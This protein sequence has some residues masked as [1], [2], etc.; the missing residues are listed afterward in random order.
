MLKAT[1]LNRNLAYPMLKNNRGAMDMGSKQH[2]KKSIGL[3]KF[4]N[5]KDA[6][7]KN[8]LEHAGMFFGA[9]L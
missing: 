2:P 4:L 8:A 1:N 5:L 7:S 9:M 6:R 3:R